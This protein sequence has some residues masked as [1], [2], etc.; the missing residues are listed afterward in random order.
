MERAV[1][2]GLKPLFGGLSD[3]APEGATYNDGLIHVLGAQ[4]KSEEANAAGLKSALQVSNA[5]QW[6]NSW[7]AVERARQHAVPLLGC[8]ACLV[9]VVS[10]LPF[11]SSG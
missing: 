2:Q 6:W 5:L 11:A 1:L 7:Q 4:S 10:R 3:V 9:G 8:A